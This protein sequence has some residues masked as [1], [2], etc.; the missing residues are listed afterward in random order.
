MLTN[1]APKESAALTMFRRIPVGR[2][3]VRF[4]VLSALPIAYWVT[5]D[6]GLKQTSEIN[7]ANKFLNIEEIAVIIPV[8]DNVLAD[9]EAEHL[10]RGDPAAR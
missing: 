5:G 3:Q 6:T 8:P 7:W 10:G 9:V 1:Y 4:P 2:T